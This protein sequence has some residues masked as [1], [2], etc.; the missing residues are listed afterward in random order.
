MIVA[1]PLQYIFATVVVWLLMLFLT[2]LVGL[3]SHLSDVSSGLT[4]K[5]GMYFYIS[6]D[7]D[8]LQ[9]NTK[10]L[11]LMKEL[12]DAHVPAQYISQDQA[13]SFLSKKLPY[14]VKKFQEYNIDAKL[15]ATLFVTVKSESIYESLQTILP[16]YADIIQNNNDLNK[17]ETIKWQELRVIKALDFAYFL[18]W[19]SLVLIFIFTLVMVGVILLVLM[20][21]LK[22]FSNIIELK[23]LLWS[24]YA[25]MRSPFLLFV[26][27]L[28]WLGYLLSLILTILIGVGS[29]WSDQSLVYFSQ[30]LWVD[31]MQ[32][33]IWW[34]LL[35]WYWAV[36]LLVLAVAAFIM[37]IS[38]LVI[39]HK[40]RTAN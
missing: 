40:I 33:G 3:G 4:D 32:T 1:K 36:L 6:Q 10:V 21:K 27:S 20:L 34:L 39:E 13:E 18:R 8:P 14:I 2:L 15:P 35:W 9:A 7:I 26:G 25:Q 24:D 37:I 28:L 16:R 19:A 11:S 38:S 30:L 12:E 31:G 5:L 29:L 17:Q 23:K 22:Q